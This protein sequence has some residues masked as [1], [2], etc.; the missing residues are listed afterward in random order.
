MH[1]PASEGIFLYSGRNFKT[2]LNA[3]YNK[4]WHGIQ[5]NHKSLIFIKDSLIVLRKLVR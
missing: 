1:R 2:Q 4:F 3:T 5:D